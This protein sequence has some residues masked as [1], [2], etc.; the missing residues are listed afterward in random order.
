MD[1]LIGVINRGL[2]IFCIGLSSVLVICV[3][4]QVFSRYVLNTPSTTTDELARFLF[5]WV[6]LMGAAYT[7]G[8]KR[9]LAI[10][11]LEQILE[12]NPAKHSILRL[13][14]N[15]IS[16]IFAS[17]IMVYGGGKLMLHVLETGQIS[18]ALSLEMGYVYAAIPLSGIFMLIYLT[19]DFLT[20]LRTLMCSKS[21]K[22]DSVANQLK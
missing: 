3:V 13:V 12:K 8:Q 6:G 17:V 10:E 7:L 14:I 15:A 16:I 1:K 21:H 18:P 9:H 19:T 20:N 22:E 11:L 5:I 2:S 4:W